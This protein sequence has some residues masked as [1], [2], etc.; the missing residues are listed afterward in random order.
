MPERTLMEA[1]RNVQH[2][3][4]WSRHWGLRS[5]KEM[6]D[7]KDRSATDFEAEIGA[8]HSTMARL[9]LILLPT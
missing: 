4:E 1:L 3:T 8:S 6:L 5:G 9:L 2:W 7:F